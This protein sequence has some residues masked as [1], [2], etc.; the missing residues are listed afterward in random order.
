MKRNSITTLLVLFM[1][2]GAIAQIPGQKP[3]EAPLGPEVPHYTMTD[4]PL[5]PLVR[6]KDP[7]KQIRML[8]DFAAKHPNPSL[9]VYIYPLYYQAYGRLQNYQMVIEYAEK[10]LALGDKADPGIRYGALYARSVAYNNLNS[11]DPALAA[12]ARERALEGA[13][14]VAVFKKPQNLDDD[15]FEAQK[16]RAAIYFQATA[17]TRRAA[18]SKIE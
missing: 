14:L 1:T 7:E 6:E 17:G 8:D 10:L 15:V 9:L 3:P 16:R 13:K 12:K 18:A 2:Y 11:L 5:E 4:D